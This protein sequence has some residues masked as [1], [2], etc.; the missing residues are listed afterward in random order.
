MTNNLFDLSHKIAKSN[1]YSDTNAQTKKNLK[2][3]LQSLVKNG[4]RL[5]L[6]ILTS[7][8]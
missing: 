6:M 2:L 5:F 4:G 1:N 8:T 7:L 3:G